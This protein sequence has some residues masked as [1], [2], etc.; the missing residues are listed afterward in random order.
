MID[1]LA[2]SPLRK[3]LWGSRGLLAG[4]EARFMVGT[5]GDCIP[6]PPE[7]G[8]RMRAYQ[9]TQCTFWFG[10]NISR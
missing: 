4:V 5:E 1:S 7:K 3:L 2:N 8:E 9:N 6:S 10:S